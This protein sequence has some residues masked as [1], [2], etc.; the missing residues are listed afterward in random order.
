MHNPHTH[1]HKA[2]ALLFCCI[3]T[4]GKRS[5]Q[6]RQDNN[7]VYSTTSGW[8]IKVR[9]GE[10]REEKRRK[11]RER[12]RKHNKALHI[13][14]FLNQEFDQN[15]FFQLPTEFFDPRTI[16]NLMQCNDQSPMTK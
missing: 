10:R 13:I 5:E 16:S 2:Q 4:V 6:R 11:E 8:V 12:E 15:A 9:K 7:T 14:L 1:T 3:S